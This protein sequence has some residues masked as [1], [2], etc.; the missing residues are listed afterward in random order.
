MSLNPILTARISL[1][2]VGLV[3]YMKIRS[4]MK[5]FYLVSFVGLIVDVQTRFSGVNVPMCHL[6]IQTKLGGHH[7][8][9]VLLVC[10]KSAK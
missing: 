10:G 8:T 3:F 4:T 7:V 5:T 9:L 2:M 6:S 1:W